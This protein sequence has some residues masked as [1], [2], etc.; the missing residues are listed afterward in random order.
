MS[1]KDRFPHEERDRRRRRYAS[2]RAGKVT[3]RAA[4]R[5]L[6]SFPVTIHV[7]NGGGHVYKARAWDISDGGLALENLDIPQGEQRIS[8]DFDIPAGTMPEEY[9][10]NGYHVEGRVVHHE[11]GRV[12]VAFGEP[13]SMRLADRLWTGM[14]WFAAVTLFL[15]VSVILLIKYQNVYFFWFDVP[16]F[17][18]GLAVGT[19]LLTRFLFAAFYR[20]PKPRDDLPKVSIII[21]A[22]N[23][24]QQLRRTLEHALESDYPDDLL[25]V[26]TVNDGSKDGTLGV[27]HEVRRRY[28]ELVV[29]DFGEQRG[30]RHALAAGTK[31]ASGEVLVFV[32]SDSVLRPDAIRN[33][34]DGFSDPGVAAVCGHCEVEN[35]WTNLL[36]RM[37]AV[38]Y[39]I[40]FRVMKG[41]ESIFDSV[42]CLSGPL[43][44]YRREALTPV[45][46]EWV[47]Q[48]F[49][50]QPAT[51]GDDRSLTNF[52][53]RRHKIRYDSRARTRTMVPDEYGTFF[54]QQLRWKRSWFR[55]SVR[56]AGFMWRKEPLM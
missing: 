11:P 28:P 31:L 55:E 35:E 36:T 23:E 27:M 50:G 22:F 15:A 42:T 30:K 5:Y 1:Q 34:V 14:R 44:A 33:I 54:R 47:T 20:P 38:R 37:Q 56:A 21:P 41:A 13:L 17:L 53:L 9:V 2:S 16:I 51:Y 24:E 46:D 8:L 48:T 12:G 39:Y 7:G 25:Q 40:G 19:Y 45:L 18:Y 3:R 26:I 4:P 10:H 29:V 43:A 49:L 52:L 32:D 6:A